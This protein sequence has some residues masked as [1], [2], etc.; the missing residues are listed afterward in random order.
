MIKQGLVMA[1]IMVIAGCSKTSQFSNAPA[2]TGQWVWNNPE[3]Y[4]KADLNLITDADLDKSFSSAKNQC[5]IEALRVPKPAPSCYQP[6]RMDCTGMVGVSLGFCQ[7]FTPPRECDYSGV[8]AAQEAQDSIYESCMSLAGWEKKWKSYGEIKIPTPK[9]EDPKKTDTLMLAIES[10]PELYRWYV[11]DGKSWEL[12][13]N[14]DDTLKV[15]P[16]Y[17]ELSLR[18]RF[19]IVV[20]RVK[21]EQANQ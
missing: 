11:E 21:R 16:E 18:E 13:M 19:L 10:I 12:A 9:R 15:L 5:R 6:P 20:D 1:V 14:M 7:A 4:A 17:Q 8:N 3:L 2:P